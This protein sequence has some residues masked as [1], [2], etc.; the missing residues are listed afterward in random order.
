MKT[1]KALV[2]G[3]LL[4][5]ETICFAEIT[6]PGWYKATDLVPGTSGEASPAMTPK[7][8]ANKVQTVQPMSVGYS[9]IA[10]AITPDIQALARG[11]ENDPLRIFKYVHDHIEFVPYFGSKKGAELT[12]LEQSGNDFDQ[13]ALLVALLRAAGYNNVGYQFGMV[14]I[15]EY[16]LISIFKLTYGYNVDYYPDWP[17][18]TNDISQL[19][20]AR[21]YPPQL[22]SDDGVFDISIPHVW[23]HLTVGTTNYYLDPTFKHNQQIGGINLA[24]RMALNTNTL[25]TSAGGTSTTNYVKGLNEAALDNTLQTLDGNLLNTIQSLFPN[26]SVQQILGGWK[27]IPWTGGLNQSP[28]AGTMQDWTYIPTNFM[29]TFEIDC[30]QTNLNYFNPQLQSTNLLSC[31][32]PQLEGRRI[33]LTFSNMYFLGIPG[34]T[35]FGA[36]LWLGDALVGVATQIPTNLLV[37]FKVK[38]PYGGWNGDPVD[39]GRFDISVTNTYLANTNNYYGIIYA[40]EPSPYWLHVRQQKLDADLEEGLANGSREVTCE[41]LN[42]M[43]LNWMVQTKLCDDILSQPYM[44]PNSPNWLSTQVGGELPQYHI[45]LG[46]MAQEVGRGYYVDI[47]CQFDGSFPSGV[48]PSNPGS[49]GTVPC[50]PDYPGHDKV[51]DVKYYFASAMEHGLIEQLQDSSLVAASTV[52]ILQLANTNKLSIYLAN[53]ADWTNGTDVRSHLSSYNLGT[54]DNLINNGYTLLLPSSGAVRIAGSGSWKGDGYVEQ[55]KTSS[56]ESIGMIIGGGYNGGYV[57][58]PY[59]VI[60]PP[61]ISFFDFS[62]PQ[63]V[64]IAPIPT[65]VITAADPVNMADASFRVADTDLSLGDAEPRGMTLSRYYSS[66]RKNLNLAYMGPGWVNSFYFNLAEISDPEASMG[67]TT[68]AQMAPMLTAT[69]AALN[70]YNTQPD[71]KNWVMTALIAKWGVDQI[72][73]KAI[74]IT[75][76]DKTLQFIKQPDGSFTPPAN[77]TWTLTKPSNYVLQE[78]HGNTFAF[79]SS[80]QLSSITDPSGNALTLSYSGDHVV[81]VRDWKGRKLTF[82]YA[83]NPTRLTSVTDNTGRSVSYGY[84]QVV[85]NSGFTTIVYTPTNAD[86]ISVTDPENKTSTYLYD[87]NHQ[88]IAHRDALGQLVV[89]NI[90]DSLGH[91]ATQYTEGDTDKTWQIYWS[92]WETVCQDPAGYKQR[93][94]YD[95]TTRLVGQQDALG[96]LSQTIY[97]GQD[98][99]VETISPLN[100]TN[101]YFYDGSNNLVQ[102]IDPLN[103]TNQFVYDGQNNL[104]QVIDALGHTNSF[105][106]DS[107][108]RLTGATNAAGDWV[109]FTYNGN[110][111]V[112]TKVD[113]GGLTAY[114]Y[115]GWGT[116]SGIVYPGGLGSDTFDNNTYGDVLT[117]TD[118]RGFVTRYYYNLRRQLT[119]TVA[120]TNVSVQVAYDAVG[121]V[122]NTTDAR[123]FVTSNIWSPTRKL[124]ATIMPATPQG[125]PI[126]TNIYDGRDDLIESLDPLQE[127]VLYTNDA[128]GRTISTTDPLLRTTSVGYD[129]DGRKIAI[130]NAAQQVT[131]LQWDKRGLLIS[132]NDP[133]HRKALYVYDGAGNQITLTNRNGN[134]W[135]FQFDA[136]N[137]LTNTIS[138]LKHQI[139]E[140][141]NNRGLLASAR[142]PS[143][144]TQSFYYD[145]KGRLTNRTDNV[146]T[147]FYQYDADDN[148]TNATENG[149]TDSWTYDAYDRVS[150]FRDVYGDLIQYGY[151]ANN[152]LT[153]LV[154]P[155]GKT[156]YYAYDSHNH[157]TNVMD[158]AGRITSYTYD[159]AGRL[160]NITHPNGTQETVTY[161][162]AGEKIKILDQT[163]AGNVISFYVLGWN[164]AARLES[165][166]AAPLPHASAIPTRD[167]TFD[168]DNRL[169]TVDGNNVTMDVDGNMTSGPLTNDT[170]F[171]Y[172]YDARNRLLDA[173]GV[174]NAYDSAGN[175]VGQTYGTNT[176]SYVISPNAKLSETLM[177]IKN[178]VTTYY[179]YG[180]GLLYQV[181]ETPTV[182]NTLTYHYDC[183]GSTVALTDDN[184]NVADHMEYSAYATL[185]YRSGTNDTPFLFNGLY[186]VMTDPNGLLNM[187]TR[188][189]NPY[190]CRFI[191]ADPSGF[192]GGLN[193]YAY[194]G[195]NPVSYLDPFGMGAVSDNFLSP[196]WL[197]APTP[198]PQYNPVIDDML[199]GP[200]IAQQMHWQQMEADFVNFA[201]L[202]LGNLA[203]SYISGTDLGGRNNLDPATAF[204]QTL[205][206]SVQV[207]A[208]TLALPTDGG[209]LE[210]DVA[211]GGADVAAADTGITVA[212]SGGGDILPATVVRQIQQGEK[213]SNLIDEV[214]QL[215]YES[216]GQEHAIVSLQSGDRVIVSGGTGGIDFS[217]MDAIKSFIDEISSVHRQK[218]HKSMNSVGFPGVLEEKPPAGQLF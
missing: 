125:T 86:L 67:S 157:L 198:I 211:L 83:S 140:T 12:L 37:T 2:L 18:I 5:T 72:T 33:S 10:E 42:V 107:E 135:Q 63:Y 206:A 88:M 90:Y 118:P 217:G 73:G 35:E 178:G 121:N 28:I 62:Q 138:P 57:S 179:V 77:C 104:I 142:E 113:P 171:A 56:G 80:K 19:L 182:T 69:C 74:S 148:L 102:T 44:T 105:G 197:R 97:D 109:N 64:D 218:A 16:D 31:F 146:G 54:L 191:N 132:T 116:L 120:P 215:T 4:L 163:A 210:A 207:A 181:T 133:A 184:G 34:P 162:A 159:L 95:D 177:R 131:T 94:F 81:G 29:V 8:T 136:A 173:G 87:K 26:D 208:L 6:Q 214:A 139:S 190:L 147:T 110:G 45:R 200:S 39:T 123:G 91:V 216:G 170:L 156:V 144:H 99:V 119:K 137:R 199:S 9:P 30:E 24:W 65:P 141:Y 55:H 192:K 193:W 213:V 59:A 14:S 145:A 85:T 71:P 169:A 195:G 40:F 47:Y 201:T 153:Q 205:Q 20:V 78:R 154:Y 61:F 93:Y 112:A 168:D 108:F 106:Y 187:R 196:S 7:T 23:V 130:T 38:Y 53:S 27:I 101:Q 180:I 172:N 165:E 11:L 98:H 96:N 186:G 160:V 189:Y 209:S 183:R 212:S 13:C 128:V 202:G 149:L 204:Q 164:S 3:I 176:I 122:A 41:T 21:G 175:R 70:L 129:A 50:V 143:G 158:W 89:T 117:H 92:G 151:D 15:N 155:G 32:M 114:L 82:N 203:S 60:N 115:D 124:M 134:V 49:V 166:F 52:K 51:F 76:G 150:S 126:T 25:Y 79:N 103:F 68:P 84:S 174:T 1:K 185:T 100:E 43:G 194:A 48:I 167:L 127:P 152:N 188:Y 36:Q 22:F 161:D 17:S 58:D 75:L 66:S 46:R 111:T